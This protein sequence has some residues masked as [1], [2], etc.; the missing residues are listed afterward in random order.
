MRL[1]LILFAMIALVVPADA[2][3]YLD[4]GAG[5]YITQ[6]VIGFLV[7]GL[8]MTRGYITKFKEWVLRIKS[9]EPMQRQ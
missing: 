2:K 8:Y 5:S 1:L 4:P 9:K 3:A 7:G 6:L